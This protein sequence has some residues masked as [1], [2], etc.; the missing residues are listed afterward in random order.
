MAE[1]KS[2]FQK[3]LRQKTSS[4]CEEKLYSQHWLRLGIFQEYKVLQFTKSVQNTK[5][6][7]HIVV[8]DDITHELNGHR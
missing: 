1:T 8:K 7:H 6:F 3:Q 5:L 4:S 2:P